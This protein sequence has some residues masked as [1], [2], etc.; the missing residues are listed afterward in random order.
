MIYPC[1]LAR[2]RSPAAVSYGGN[3]P[4]ILTLVKSGIDNRFNVIAFHQVGLATKLHQPDFLCDASW[5]TPGR[6]KARTAAV[7][8]SRTPLS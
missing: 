8:L 5:V 3:P 2:E 7:T 4:L 1:S 6:G